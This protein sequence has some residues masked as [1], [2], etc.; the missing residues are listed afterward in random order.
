MEEQELARGEGIGVGGPR[1]GDGGT[2]V[3]VCPD[4]GAEIAHARGVPCVESKC[5]KCGSSMVGKPVS[6]SMTGLDEEPDLCDELDQLSKKKATDADIPPDS[7]NNQEI[8]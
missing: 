1:Q 3:C 6:M 5:P 4:C 7:S 8:L 2:D